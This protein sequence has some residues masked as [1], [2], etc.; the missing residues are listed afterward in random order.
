MSAVVAPS[1]LE[2]I[3]LG[4]TY[5]RYESP[6]TRLKTLLTGHGRGAE[7]SALA[8]VSFVLQ[9]GQCL[10]VVGDNGAGKSTLL[11]LITGVLRPSSGHVRKYG[12]LTAILELGAGFHPE[13][14]GRNNIHFAGGLIGIPAEEMQRLESEIIAFAELG[15]AIDQP[16]KTFSSGMVVRLAF[17]LMTSV[18]PDI[19]I[20]DEALAVGDQHFQKKCIDRIDGF[21]KAGCIILFCSHSLY[22]IR[23]LC[24]QSLWLDQGRVRGLGDTEA[25]LASYET[26]IRAMDCRV[27]EDP[28][29]PKAAHEA[30][31][32]SKA[33]IETVMLAGLDDS[34][35]PLLQVKDLEITVTALS[36]GTEVPNIAVM[37]KRADGVGITAV[38]THADGVSPASLGDGRWQ[39]VLTFPELP[40]Y[41]GEY[42]VSAYLF[43]A[44]GVLVYDEWPE[45]AR[46]RHVFPT[47]EVGLVRLPHRWS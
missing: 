34:T 24:D 38:G 19:L 18:S 39:A 15:S 10:G 29:A 27:G 16:V 26:H 11:K 36:K 6:R 33:A 32:E 14:T 25:V 35:P 20:I 41:S 37:L 13:F 17:S 12:R 31:H 7:H 46:F 40:L 1:S 43:D 42:T 47:L 3:G 9:R 45:C 22:H 23:R 44:Q 28:P 8:D 2:V 4:K 30:G 5:A 21:R